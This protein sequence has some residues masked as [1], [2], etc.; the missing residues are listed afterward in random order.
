MDLNLGEMSGSQSHEYGYHSQPS[1]GYTF[2]SPHLSHKMNANQTFLLWQSFNLI[3]KPVLGTVA[4]R[5]HRVQGDLYKRKH[6]IGG[7]LLTV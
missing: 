4:V 3:N 5:G 7:A 6:L 1:Q 2:L